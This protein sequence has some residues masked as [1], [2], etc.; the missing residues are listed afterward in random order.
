MLSVIGITAFILLN[1]FLD[2]SAS[3]K[4]SG[5]IMKWLFPNTPETNGVVE[6]FWLRKAA[7]LAEYGLLGVAVGGGITF[8][9]HNYNKRVIGISL[10][11]ILAIAVLDEFIQSFSDRTSSVLDVMLDFGGATIGLLLLFTTV[12]LV[13]YIKSRNKR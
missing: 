9:H 1:S 2:F 5:I 8:L 3:H 13:G 12:W 7:H 11:G 4:L 6:D 10:F